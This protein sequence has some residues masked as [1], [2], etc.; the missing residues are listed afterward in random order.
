MELY[1]LRRPIIL[2]FNFCT[3]DYLLISSIF[4]QLLSNILGKVKALSFSQFKFISVC[5]CV[6]VCVCFN[7]GVY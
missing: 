5:V 6:C 7:G 1:C 3:L 4:F 2:I